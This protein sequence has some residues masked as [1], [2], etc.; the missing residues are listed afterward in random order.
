MSLPVWGWKTCASIIPAQRRG[1]YAIEKRLFK[2]GSVS[3]MNGVLGYDECIFME[4]T[5]LTVLREGEGDSAKGVWMSDSPI[6]YYSMWELVARCVGGRVLVG[7]LG[8]GILT[9]LLALR[10]DVS[11][12]TVVEIAPEVIEM[13]QPYLSQYI[14][15][16]IIGRDFL[17]SWKLEEKD[18]DSVIID[19]FIGTPEE[20]KLFQDVQSLMES[21]FTDAQHL[22]WAYQKDHELELL[23]HALWSSKTDEERGKN[24][25]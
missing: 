12:L 15:I 25:K 22:Y 17:D 4:D 19:I 8:L 3:P 11:S 1:D 10:R 2:K 7:G 9:N 16:K 6:E 21:R 18:F 24:R 13:V 5:F 20:R 23:Q 14:P